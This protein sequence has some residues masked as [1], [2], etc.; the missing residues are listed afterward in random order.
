MSTRPSTLL[1]VEDEYA[2]FCLDEIVYEWGQ[3]VDGEM[4]KA[5]VTDRQQRRSMEK[6]QGRMKTVLM[7]LLGGK[8][9]AD[10]A[11]RVNSDR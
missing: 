9:F 1:G 5:S 4:E 3:F 10:P 2:A 7:N 11:E 8:R 6:A